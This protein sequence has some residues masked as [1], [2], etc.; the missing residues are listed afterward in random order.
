MIIR[1]ETVE[2]KKDPWALVGLVSWRTSPGKWFPDFNKG[3]NWTWRETWKEENIV[4]LFQVVL[5]VDVMDQHTLSSP[6]FGD[7]CKNIIEPKT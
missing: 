5:V 6:R 3:F 4:V 2:G 7:F 1:E